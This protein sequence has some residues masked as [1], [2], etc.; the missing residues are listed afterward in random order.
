V[1]STTSIDPLSEAVSVYRRAFDAFRQCPSDQYGQLGRSPRRRT[2][3]NEYVE[4][5]DALVAALA[6]TPGQ[7]YT[8]EAGRTLYFTRFDRALNRLVLGWAP[9]RPSSVNAD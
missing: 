1:N 2:L 7:R 9:L 8:D 6:S 5:R 3:W 4:A